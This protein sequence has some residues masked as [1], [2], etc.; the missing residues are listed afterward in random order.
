[1]QI[2]PAT[3]ADVPCMIRLDRQSATAGHWTE[4]QYRQA[5][6]SLRTKRLVLVIDEPSVPEAPTSVQAFLVAQHIPPE[7]ELEN[8]VVA[9]TARRKGLGKRLLQSLLSIARESNSDSVFLEVRDSNTA[10]RTL[11]EQ[12]GFLQTGRR[13]SYYTNPQEDAVLYR[14]S[15]P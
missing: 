10:A 7:W 2:R 6:E 8:I 3:L 5:L 12:A 9:A 15:L 13:K 11:Y 14:K 4:D 1:M